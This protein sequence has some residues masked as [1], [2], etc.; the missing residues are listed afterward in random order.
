MPIN[1]P[2]EYYKAEEKYLKAKT[3]DEKIAALEEMI[4]LLPKHKGTENLLAQLR[5]RLAKLKKQKEQKKK[6]GK[7]SK[8]KEL[9]VEKEGSAQVCIIG[10]PNSGK[11][12]LLKSLTNKE[13]EISE[14][15]YTT[16]KPEVAM[17]DY[18]NVKIQ[19][20]EIP[21]TFE[22][23]TF[24]ILNNCDL[25]VCL[26]DSTSDINEQK[27]FFEEMLSKR[28][29]LKKTI[30]VISKDDSNK[31]RGISIKRKESLEKLK[32]KIWNSLNLIRV[33]PKPINKKP[34]KTPI[35]LPKGS[36]VKD[37]V[38]KLGYTFI[39][40]FKFARIFDN[41]KFSGRKVGLDYEL[42]DKDIV[43]VHLD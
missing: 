29:L 23:Y 1:A 35:T 11:S 27:K 22:P 21:S 17:L 14:I 40:N 15:P 12:S 42:K 26:L 39:K 36:K 41:S 24:G 16:K 6:V 32:E 20:V 7:S 34:E 4:R 38:E 19:L 5:K 25:I 18:E 8:A 31:F 43:E 30:F 13:I 10:Y 9:T 3:I 33:Y 28:N 2:I 37:F